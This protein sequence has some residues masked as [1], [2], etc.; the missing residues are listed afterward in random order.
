MKNKTC[1]ECCHLEKTKHFSFQCEHCN[2]TVST[3]NTAC[4]HFVERYGICSKCGS[5]LFFYDHTE[6]NDR[7]LCTC[8]SCGYSGTPEEFLYNYVFARITASLAA[9]SDSIAATV[10]K[11]KEIYND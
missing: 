8:E 4:N 1:G 9:L 5:Y 10:E 3:S 7:L 11:L 2:G 6:D